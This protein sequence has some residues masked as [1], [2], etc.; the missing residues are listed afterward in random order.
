MFFGWKE[1]GSELLRQ[2][3]HNQYFDKILYQQN[4]SKTHQKANCI[5]NGVVFGVIIR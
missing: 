1:M 3:I 5:A 2:T 4:L